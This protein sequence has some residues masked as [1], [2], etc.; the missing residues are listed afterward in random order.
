MIRLLQKL[1]ADRD[2]ARVRHRWPAKR[3]GSKSAARRSSE[4]AVFAAA[5]ATVRASLAKEEEASVSKNPTSD[6]QS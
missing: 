3:H 1:D 2:Y 5:I 6:R 4:P